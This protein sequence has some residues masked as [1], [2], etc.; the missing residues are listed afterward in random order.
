ML[1][2]LGVLV[3]LSAV[4]FDVGTVTAADPMKEKEAKPTISERLTKDGIKGTLAED[5]W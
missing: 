4:S 3:I 1:R 2:L 5:R